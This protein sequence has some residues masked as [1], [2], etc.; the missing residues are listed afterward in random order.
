MLAIEYEV[1]NTLS[2]LAELGL[3]H[4]T[5]CHDIPSEH[6]ETEKQLLAKIGDMLF[7]YEGEVLDD[8]EE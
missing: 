5:E 7:E 1:L 8:M 4:L 6:L 2:K 3:A